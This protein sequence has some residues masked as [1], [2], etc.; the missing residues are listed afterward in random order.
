MVERQSPREAAAAMLAA[1]LGGAQ[2]LAC[3]LAGVELLD[4]VVLCSAANSVLGGFG[5]VDLCAASA[6][7][8][9]AAAAWPGPAA[10]AW[11]SIGIPGGT[12]APRSRSRCR[13]T[14][15][16]CIARACGTA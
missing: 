12:S 16:S 1:K 14:L 7:L 4:F 15:W 3:L 6:G 10:L 5:Q 11:R 8:D 13:P 9:A 2:V